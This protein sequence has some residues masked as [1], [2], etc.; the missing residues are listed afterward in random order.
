M[1]KK[2]L[3]LLFYI[4]IRYNHSSHSFVNIFLTRLYCGTS[5]YYIIFTIT[6]FYPRPKCIRLDL[7]K[8]NENKF[9]HIVLRN[10]VMNYGNMF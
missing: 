6:F 8:D 1:F 7:Y 4:G 9:T 2:K 5:E 10:H 3:L